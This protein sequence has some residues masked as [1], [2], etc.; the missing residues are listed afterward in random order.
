M[1]DTDQAAVL[2]FL[3]AGA[4]GT[5][6]ERIDTHGAIILLAGDRA[7]KLKR[8]VRFSFMDFLTLERREAALRTELALNRRTAPMLYRRVLAVTREPGDGLALAGTGPAVEW[9]LEMARFPA[10]AQLDRVAAR[11]ELTEPMIETLAEIVA[12][13]HATAEVR[14]D[15]GGYP[16]MRAVVAGNA[17]DLA[18]LAPEALDATEVDRLNRATEDMLEVSASLLEQRRVAG[19]V[20]HCHGDLHLA[21]IVQLDGRPVLFDCLEFDEA[22]ACTDVLYDLAFLVM[23][24]IE[25]GLPSHAR[26]L[27]QIYGDITG[28]D[29]G[30][31]L[32]P[33]FIAVRATVR[34][35]VAG[36][37]ARVLK[38]DDRVN[39]L[40]AAKAYLALALRAL[41][42]VPARLLVVGGRSGTGKSSV[43]AALAPALGAM[44]G[45][46][47]LR[48]D[49]IRKRL[50]GRSPV[51]RLPSEA[52]RSAV[53]DR[54][55]G[56]IAARADALVRAGRT[57]IAD[58]VYGDP[59]QRAQIEATARQAGVPFRAVWLAAP[60]AMLECRVA[61]R[62][63]DASDADVQV[64]RRQA[65]TLTDAAVGWPKVA[66]GR[67]LAEVAAD[68]RRIWED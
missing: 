4:L 26:L 32:L 5:R 48:S 38:G 58:G 51:D 33:L 14:R 62:T 3:E 67:A 60:E 64:V 19:R 68:V 55:F 17:A 53:S 65:R 45:A 49:V 34:A 46:M 6:V 2:S 13:F 22:L 42:P 28:D 15:Q 24:L 10:E 57:V 61:A 50:L 47:V 54:V 1:T 12:A 31:A 8:A 52:Y 29:A 35:K 56:T 7:Y 20:R 66:A 21:N 63:G 36:F 44:P 59:A 11:G 27:L 16:A 18:S 9:L 37:N 43:A 25:R 39:K 40:A 23:D 30:L 41:E